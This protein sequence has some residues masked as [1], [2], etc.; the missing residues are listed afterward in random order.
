MND[1]DDPRTPCASD[2]TIVTD[3]G[4][5][6]LHPNEHLLLTCSG[7]LAEIPTLKPGP[8]DLVAGLLGR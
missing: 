7:H 2:I 5:R 4:R 1:I 6:A 8:V 3:A